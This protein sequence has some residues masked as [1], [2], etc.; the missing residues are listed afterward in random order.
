MLRLGRVRL[1]GETD[2]ARLLE[3]GKKVLAAW[4]GSAEVPPGWDVDAEAIRQ[5]WNAFAGQIAPSETVLLVSSNG[6]IRF[7]PHLLKT[8]YPQFS[9]EHKI[10]VSTGGVC[11]FENDG[12]GW[13]CAVW[14][15]KPA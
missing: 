5:N 10:K 6:V 1:P 8:G 4:D 12:S 14:N 2:G 13:T 15:S 7:A 3:E 11:V 9:A